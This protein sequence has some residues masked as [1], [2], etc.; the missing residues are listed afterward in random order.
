V[1]SLNF[2]LNGLFVVAPGRSAPSS[3]IKAHRSAKLIVT[4]T[5]NNNFSTPLIPGPVDL[6]YGTNGI[7]YVMLIQ[8]IY[9]L[10]E[11]SAPVFQTAAT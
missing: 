4:G 6:D 10:L 1:G 8:S 11:N 9:H 3:G 5:R 2:Q 7:I